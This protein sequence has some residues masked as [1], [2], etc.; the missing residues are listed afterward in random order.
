M[1]KIFVL[2]FAAFFTSYVNAQSYV[3]EGNSVVFT[4]VLED[5][6]MS[7]SEMHNSLEA[8]FAIT[9]NNVNS[10]E[11]LNQPDHLIYKGIFADVAFYMMGMWSSD[12]N[13][14]VDIALKDGRVRIKISLTEVRAHSSS[15]EAH[16][17][18]CETWPIK[19]QSAGGNAPIKKACVST[20]EGASNEVNGLFLAIEEALKNT[21]SNDDW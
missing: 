10:T 20:F 19:D 16:Y 11:K 14:T 7:I 5:T 21:A 2:L 9:Y 1:R 8:F 4:K 17:N 13:H 12:V 15:A 6:G 3:V 18:I